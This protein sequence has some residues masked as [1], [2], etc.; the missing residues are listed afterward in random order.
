MGITLLE[1]A[2]VP[3]GW[4]GDSL[5]EEL[6]PTMRHTEDPWTTCASRNDVRRFC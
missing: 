1:V 6:L 2:L 5:Q 3:Y 4:F